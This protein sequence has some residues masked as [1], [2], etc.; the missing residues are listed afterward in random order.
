MD[1]AAAAPPGSRLRKH[2]PRRNALA[3]FSA[4]FLSGARFGKIAIGLFKH[5][6]LI[7]VAQLT[8]KIGVP[9][10]GGL[11]GFFFHR[12]LFEIAVRVLLSWHRTLIVP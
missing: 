5:F 9:V 6:I 2:A 1:E 10:G 12:S 4:V 11:A 7:A 3:L 8:M